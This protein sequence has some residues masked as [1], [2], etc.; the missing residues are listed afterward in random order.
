M[1]PNKPERW[2]TIWCKV[3]STKAVP[4]V[5]RQV[6]NY[7]RIHVKVTKNVFLT[8]EICEKL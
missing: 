3:T 5:V 7:E 4:L 1:K 2:L 6:N 8:L